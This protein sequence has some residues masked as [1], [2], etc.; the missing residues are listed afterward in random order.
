MFLTG[1]FWGG[2][3][4]MTCLREQPTVVKMLIL[5][6]AVYLLVLRFEAGIAQQIILFLRSVSI[7]L[8]FDL[9]FR[10]KKR[11]DFTAMN[12]QSAG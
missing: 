1:I 4:A 2:I 9:I 6:S 12:Q 7:I 8:L 3:G 10:I 11:P 5:A